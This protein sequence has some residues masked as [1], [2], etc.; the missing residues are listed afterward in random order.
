MKRSGFTLIELIF[1]IVII[2]VLSAIAIPKFQHLKQNAEAAGVIKTS[3]DAINSIPSTYVNMKDLEDDNATASNL[4]KIV[5]VAGKGWKFAGT[6]GLNGQTYTYTDPAATSGDH[7][8][9][10]I[11]FNP[12]DRNATLNI[13]CTK[14]V[15]TTT[16]V[17]C[18][19]KLGDNNT[20][21]INVSF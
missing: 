12:N 14:F 4:Q 17:K 8:V 11:T 13:N 10:V 15:D 2:G 20:T 5:K 18:A 16:Q 9:S 1:V 7:N 19:S 6:A 3:V 21:D